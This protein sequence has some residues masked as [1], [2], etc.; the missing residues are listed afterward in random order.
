MSGDIRQSGGGAADG[1]VWGNINTGDNQYGRSSQWAVPNNTSGNPA[2]TERTIERGLRELHQ[3]RQALQS[4]PG[5]VKEIDELARKMRGLDPRR[6]PGNPALVEQLHGEVLSSIDR[7]ELQVEREAAADQPRTGKPYVVP[8]GYEDSVADY[9]R[10][11]SRNQQI[12][13]P[14]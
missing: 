11:L 1:T 14:D 7:L 9:Y 6:F 2:D 8:P 4:D 5:A 10:R 3:L 12:Q 13:P